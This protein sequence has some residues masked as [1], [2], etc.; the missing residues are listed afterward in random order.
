MTV[1]V[2]AARTVSLNS[3]FARE[4]RAA[5]MIKV[6]EQAQAI[7][8]DAVDETNKIVTKEYVVDRPPNRRKGGRHLLG[9]FRAQ[10]IPAPPGGLVRIKMRSFG[11]NPDKVNALND[12]SPPHVIPAPPGGLRFPRGT[13][14][15][16]VPSTHRPSALRFRQ[17][18]GGPQ[19]LIKTKVDHPGTGAGRFMQRGL[20]RAV[21]RAYGSKVSVD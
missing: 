8:Q 19:I 11:T 5:G 13:P 1:K 7:A 14:R 6:A 3:S 4:L 9:S 15:G 18:Y 10:V 12:G 2:T 17:G 21:Q 16:A 20:E